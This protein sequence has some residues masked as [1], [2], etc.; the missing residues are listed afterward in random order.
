[1][2]DEDQIIDTALMPYNEQVRGVVG[3]N[4]RL[5]PLQRRLG[6][7]KA[8]AEVFSSDAHGEP[9][10]PMLEAFGGDAVKVHI[11]VP[12]SEQTHVFSLEG[13]Q[14]PYEPGRSGSDMLSSVRVGGLE[15]VTLVL[16]RGRAV[17][18]SCPAIISMAITGSRS[19]KPDCG[20]YSA[21][22]RRA[23]QTTGSSPW[24]P[25]ETGQQAA[26]RLHQW[27]DTVPVGRGICILRRGGPPCLPLSPACLRP[28]EGIPTGC[29]R[30]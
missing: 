25:A 13:H 11:L 24:Q 30:R 10:T 29:R 19:G 15:A 3:V 28:G 6:N 18:V 9:A 27:A 7:G 1:M 5:E 21:S 22:T 20:G 23:R 17:V 12:F 16:D 2:Q 4:Y 26:P 14:W 8:T